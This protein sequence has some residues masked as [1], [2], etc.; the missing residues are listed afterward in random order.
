MDWEEE[1]DLSYI[2]DDKLRDHVLEMLRKHSS[3]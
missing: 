1:I 2:D 3:L